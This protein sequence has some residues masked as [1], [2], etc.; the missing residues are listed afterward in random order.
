MCRHDLDPSFHT[1]KVLRLSALLGLFHSPP[2]QFRGSELVVRHV[3]GRMGKA[4]TLRASGSLPLHPASTAPALSAAA[5]PPA[6]ADN[7]AAGSDKA[8]A[9]AA[10]PGITV[11]LEN[12]ELRVRNAYTG[13]WWRLLGGVGRGGRPGGCWGRVAA[14]RVQS[15]TYLPACLMG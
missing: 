7:G 13:G 3:D 12:V 11:A 6:A 2:P 9:A 1:H 5:A 8:G 10:P 15:C 14:A 4:G